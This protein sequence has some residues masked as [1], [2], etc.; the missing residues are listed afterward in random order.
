MKIIDRYIFSSFITIF[1]FCT[2]FLYILFVIGDIFGFLDEILRERIGIRELS[3]FYFYMMPFVIT[4]IA[5]ISSLLSSS[6]L[7]SVFSLSIWLFIFCL[8]LQMLFCIL[9]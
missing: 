5:P 2:L 8:L 3:A 6:A 7:V 9:K 4:Q 1:L